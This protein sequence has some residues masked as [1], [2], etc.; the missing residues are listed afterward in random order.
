MFPASL[1]TISQGAFAKC[2]NLTTVTLNEGIE[3]LGTNELTTDNKLFYG[4]FEESALRSITLPKTLRKI[5]YKAFE[6]CQNLKNITLPEGIENIGEW[7][8]Y[9]SAL[10]SIAF[11]SS[12]KTIEKGA[13]YQ[14]R[15]LKRAKLSEGLES[16]GEWCFY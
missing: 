4:V 1:R 8:F 14:C 12:L 15:S 13:F 6:N 9:E 2:K 11:P 5:E 16:I 7:C 10:E 3:V